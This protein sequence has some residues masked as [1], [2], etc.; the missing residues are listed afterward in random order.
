MEILQNFLVETS[1]DDII[2]FEVVKLHTSESRTNQ[3]IRVRA[4][5]SLCQRNDSYSK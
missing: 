4:I 3:F 2:T 5:F 1:H